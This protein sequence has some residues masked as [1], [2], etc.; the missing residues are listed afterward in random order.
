VSLP[1]VLVGDFAMGSANMY[2]IFLKLQKNF[3]WSF[4]FCPCQLCLFSGFIQDLMDGFKGFIVTFGTICR[5]F[6]LIMNSSDKML[7]LPTDFV[8]SQVQV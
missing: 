7:Q 4:V 1:Y 6:A 2:Q 8:R 5:T 3:L